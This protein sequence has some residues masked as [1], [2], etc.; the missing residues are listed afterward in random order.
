[1]KRFLLIMA[2][3]GAGVYNQANSQCTV[4]NLAIQ[5]KSVNTINNQCQVVFDLSWNQEVNNG[6]KYACIHLWRSDQYPDLNANGLAYATSSDQPTAGDLVNAIA[7]IVIEHN[8]TANP[9]I[10][11]VYDPDPTVP[12]FSSGLDVKKESVNSIWERMTVRNISLTIPACTGS[13]ITADIWASQADHGQ[14]PQCVSSS[15]SFIVGNQRIAG[16]LFCAT[17]RQYSVQIGNVGNANISVSYNI[18]IDEGDGIYE[19][20]S[21]DL[22]ITG[23]PVGPISIAP[24][25][26]YNSG[27]QAYLPYSNEKPYAD[28]G[29]WVEVM[30][31][32]FPN[33]TVAFIDNSCIPLPVN[34][35]LFTAQRNHS[36]VQLN[37]ETSTEINNTG[38]ELQRKMGQEN[39]QGIAFI[40]TKALMGNSQHQLAYNYNDMNPA[41][42]ISEYRVKQ[43]DIDGQSKYSEIRAVR[44]EGQKKGTIIY[45][46]PVKNNHAIILF[47]DANAKHD[48][49]MLDATG[50]MIKKWNN[51][52]GQNLFVDNINTGIYFLQITNVET[53]EKEIQK[54]MVMKE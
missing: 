53:E 49:M 26:T 19:P 1:M 3:A 33:V 40:P 22:K 51:Y 25:N 9:V 15:I 52:A 7:T 35:S 28:H 16:L 47:D 11:T 34:F 8:G 38:F 18:Y 39:F 32:G 30:T 36:T 4:N 41:T 21:H 31:A 6:N 54:M 45:P 13:G 20:A 2:M 27:I 43:I 29:L 48:I 50:R 10:G 37:W 12:V 44:G 17:P 42:T 24:G 46:N 23:T 5:L 14:N